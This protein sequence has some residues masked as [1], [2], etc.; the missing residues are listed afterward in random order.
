MENRNVSVL[1]KIFGIIPYRVLSVFLL[2]V[3]CNGAMGI[4]PWLQITNGQFTIQVSQVSIKT[5]FDQIEAE[6][7]YV[8]FY[9]A[10][11]DLGQKV[12]INIKRGNIR[13]TLDMVLRDTDLTYVVS[14][15]EIYVKKK[16]TAFPP[17]TAQ[18]QK[19]FRVQGVVTSPAGEPLI[20][21]NVQIEGRKG[22]TITDVNGTYTILVPNE[23]AVLIFSYIRVY[24]N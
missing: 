5:V 12:D 16:K 20:G 18:Q 13:Q 11:L 15:K 7:D 4:T 10:D 19:G 23:E 8:F 14:G 2:L 24:V 22:G 17:A 1:K 3:L 21:V 6:S 9:E